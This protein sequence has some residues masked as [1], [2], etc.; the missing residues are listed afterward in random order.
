MGRRVPGTG[1]STCDSDALVPSVNPALTDGHQCTIGRPG[2][3]RQRPE[4]HGF[5][6][7]P[8]PGLKLAQGCGSSHP[9]VH[10]CLQSDFDPFYFSPCCPPAAQILAPRITTSPPRN[11]PLMDARS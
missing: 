3:N 11:N 8:F 5:G 10:P 9:E 7:V 2:F 6:Q 4:S 1:R